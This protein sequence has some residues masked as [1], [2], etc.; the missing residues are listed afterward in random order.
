MSLESLFFSLLSC[1]LLMSLLPLFHLHLTSPSLSMPMSTQCLPVH[2]PTHPS[3]IYP[4]IYQ[5]IHACLSLSMYLNIYNLSLNSSNFCATLGKRTTSCS[6]LPLHI[7]REFLLVFRLT[8]PTHSGL[9][10]GFP[11]TPFL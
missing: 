5:S 11:Q 10:Q 2:P 7:C 3:S 8:E 4:S 6:I 9:Q 1:S